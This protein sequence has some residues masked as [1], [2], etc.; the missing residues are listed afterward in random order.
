V[1]RETASE[2]PDLPP[3]RGKIVIASRD[4]GMIS[5]LAALVCRDGFEPVVVADATAAL[6][7]AKLHQPDCIW[8][9]AAVRGLDVGRVVRI[10]H[11][12]GPT[13]ATVP[14]LIAPE[15]ISPLRLQQMVGLGASVLERPIDGQALSGAFTAALTQ[16]GEFRASHRPP[17]AK[18]VSPT[19]RV[20]GNSSLLA[21]RVACPFH[22]EP[23]PFDRYLLRTGKILTDISFYDLPVYKTPVAG[24]DFVNFHL[25]NVAVCPKCLFATNNP[26]YL[27]DPGVPHHG[28]PATTRTAVINATVERQAMAKGVSR[29][30]FTEHRTDV[31]A[32][33]A[34]QLAIHCGQILFNC[35][36]HSLPVELLRLGNY[37][38]RLAHL[39]ELQDPADPRREIE[40]VKALQW[41][42]QAFAVL[43]GPALFK[44]IYQVIA[45]AISF[46][47]DKGAY[48]Y[49]TALQNLRNEPN[50]SNA[51]LGSLDRYIARAKTAWE[52]R[53]DQRLPGVNERLAAEAA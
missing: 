34:Y 16:A 51:D 39:Y 25:L 26:E 47:D 40:A 11:R 53:E 32:M 45:L 42:K 6:D 19:R 22:E 20:E 30:F 36:R 15:K 28:F 46:G 4:E 12:Y 5:A 9:D 44:A 49:L 31:D 27:I 1:A 8:L 23:V 24:A 2:L 13:Q 29:N 10:L 48:P 18:T 52:N 21:R 14:I 35:N 3:S 50:L 37:H 17:P 41:L 38:L 43:E 33:I 7:A